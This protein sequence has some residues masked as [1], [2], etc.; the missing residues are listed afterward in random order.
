MLHIFLNLIKLNIHSRL[1]VIFYICIDFMKQAI[2][3]FYSSSIHAS[4]HIQ[5]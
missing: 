2:Y 3:T 4:F 1:K 5:Y